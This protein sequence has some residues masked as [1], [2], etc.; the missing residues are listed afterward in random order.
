MV[1]STPEALIASIRLIVKPIARFCIRRQLKVQDA[2]EQVKVAF[3]EAAEREIQR[4]GEDPNVSRLSAMT[5]MH[6]RDVVRLFRQKAPKEYSFNLVTRVIGQWQRDPRFLTKS[7]KPKVLTFEGPE[8]EFREL[9]NSVA[10][11]LKPGTV[12]FELER[13]GAIERTPEGLKLVHKTY[14]PRGSIEESFGILADDTED[15]L[16]S[17]EENVFEFENA[18]HLHAKTVYDN[19][20]VDDLDELEMIRDWVIRLGAEFHR[21]ARSYLAKYDLDINPRD[22]KFKKMRVA[23]GTFARI[24]NDDR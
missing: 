24:A 14:E 2:I 18:P 3:I 21:R 5:G 15:L 13:I 19:I 10:T 7:R 11:D 9:M 1:A 12:L 23:V 17:V 4:L 6:R 16:R 22:T 20:G 8:S